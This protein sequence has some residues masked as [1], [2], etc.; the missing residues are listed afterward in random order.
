MIFDKTYVLIELWF[1]SL[2][3]IDL[4]QEW[5][6]GRRAE[7]GLDERIRSFI[8]RYFTDFQVVSLEEKFICDAVFHFF[9]YFD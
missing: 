4:E 3:L 7:V 2:D 8:F 5:Q 6:R 9:F 1:R